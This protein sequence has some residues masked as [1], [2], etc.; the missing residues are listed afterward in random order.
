MPNHVKTRINAPKHILEDIWENYTVMDRFWNRHLD[1]SKIIPCPR[2]IFQW[3]LDTET[4]K[5]YGPENCWYQWNIRNWW[6]KWNAYEC[7][8]D[9]Y[10]EFWTAWDMPLPIIRELA[11]IYEKTS[12]LI[13]YAD[14]DIWSNCGEFLI[15]WREITEL[16]VGDKDVFAIMLWYNCDENEAK[17]IIEQDKN[18]KD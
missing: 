6:T 8:F 5:K 7:S 11:M 2:Y 13:D 16:D 18:E 15:K 10:I 9:E 4:E 1:F 17:N 14:E 3:D 12:F